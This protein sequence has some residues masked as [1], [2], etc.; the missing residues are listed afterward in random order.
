MHAFR[1]LNS[2]QLSINTAIYCRWHSGAHEFGLRLNLEQLAKG[3]VE[4]RLIHVSWIPNTLHPKQGLHP[5]SHVCADKPR[6]R[7]TP[8]VIDRNSAL[9]MHLMRHRSSC[10]SSSYN[11]TLDPLN[12]VSDGQ[13]PSV[14]Y[15]TLSAF[16]PANSPVNF[17]EW[18]SLLR[19]I[20]QLMPVICQPLN[21]KH[22]LSQFVSFL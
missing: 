7:Q 19:V 15:N 5:F 9:F 18:E 6:D 14:N 12:A 1:R 21:P 22:K 3:G 8:G 2:K 11:W 10:A 20:A 17:L 4:S 16:R 13:Y